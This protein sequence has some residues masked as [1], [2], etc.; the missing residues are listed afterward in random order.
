MKAAVLREVGKP[1]V[2]EDVKISKPGPNEAWVRIT[3]VAVFGS[4]EVMV[5]DRGGTTLEDVAA[6]GA[7]VIQKVVDQI[8]DGAARGRERARRHRFPPPKDE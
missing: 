5:R 1:L 2:I 7:E 6:K 8:T 4:V 3:G